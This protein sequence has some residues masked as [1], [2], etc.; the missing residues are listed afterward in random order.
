MLHYCLNPD[1]FYVETLLGVDDV[2]WKETWS[3]EFHDLIPIAHCPSCGDPMA[4]A[5]PC[6]YGDMP[7]A[8]RNKDGALQTKINF[9]KTS[10]RKLVS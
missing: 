3:S 4:I 9:A 7:L 2:F 6:E 8:E 10:T 5:E 1:C